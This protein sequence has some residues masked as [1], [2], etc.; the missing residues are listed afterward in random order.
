MTIAVAVKLFAVLLLFRFHLLGVMCDECYCIV[1]K[2][3]TRKIRLHVHSTIIGQLLLG[4]NATA[5]ATATTE[6]PGNVAL[7]IRPQEKLRPKKRR[8]G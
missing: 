5:T 3:Q 7:S 4:L 8:R 6:L 2:S 1:G